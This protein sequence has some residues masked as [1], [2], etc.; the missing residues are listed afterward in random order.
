MSSFEKSKEKQAK[1]VLTEAKAISRAVDAKGIENV[2][3][4]ITK[5]HASSKNE[6]FD[7]DSKGVIDTAA[8]AL[9]IR[10]KQLKE[11][12]VINASISARNL[13]L[14][15]QLDSLKRKYY[16]YNGNGLNLI[17]TPPYDSTS[18]ARADFLGS[19]NLT[20]SQGFKK[21]WLLG[22]ERTL[23]SITSDNPYFKVD[24][25]NYVGFDRKPVSFNA[26]AHLKS[27]YNKVIGA[28][29]GPGINIKLGRVD[30][31]G[32]YQYYPS[33][34]GWMFGAGASIRLVGF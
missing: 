22:R 13:Q 6:G 26:E 7:T 11:V 17:F 33:M 1:Q 29:S 21:K 3:F 5:N 34:K 10:N 30:L 15:E 14:V 19:L 2:I 32:D 27:T 18:S 16:T 28:G 8:M 31:S 25:V 4:D 24:H 12:L 23:L 20:A 9:D